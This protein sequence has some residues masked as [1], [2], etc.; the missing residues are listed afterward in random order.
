MI[1]W[2]KL[3]SFEWDRGNT[4]KNYEKHGITPKESEE[5]FLDVNLKIVRD[6]KHSQKEARFIVIGKSFGKKVLF[7]IFTLRKDKIRIISARLANKKERSR[8]EKAIKK[9]S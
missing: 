3:K 8:Y 1:N 5:V 6:V 4:D 2:G 9:D 7:I